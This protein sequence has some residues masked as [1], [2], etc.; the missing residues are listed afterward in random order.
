MT[1]LIDASPLQS[2]HRLRGVGAYVRSLVTAIESM[3]LQPQYLVSS[4]GAV[5]LLP[6]DRVTRVFR[7]HRPAQVYW[8]YNEL[9]LR[10]G[11]RRIRPSVF[12]APDFNGLVTNPYGKTVSVLHDLTHLK[13]T[14]AARSG[15]LSA[16]L[17]AL[18][19]SVYNCKLQQADC[20]LA[21]SESTRQDAIRLLGIHPDRLHVVHHGVD[22]C[23]FRPSRGRGPFAQHKPYFVQLGGRNDNKNQ[24]RLLQAFVQVAH[25][26]KDV[27]LLFSGPW[28]AADLNWLQIETEHLRIQGRVRHLGY[29]PDHDLSSL[30]GNAVAFVFPSLEEGFGLPIL[31]AMASGAA[32]ITSDRSSL[33]EVAGS[34]ALLVNPLDPADLAEAMLKVLTESDLSQQLRQAGLD[35]ARQFTWETT[36]QQTMT[37]IGRL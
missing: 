7:P 27:E 16:H 5:N 4:D 19:W 17:D 6:Q 21:I 32:V 11:L 37:V 22:H 13:L 34:A 3:G 29:V 8:M 25:L 12:L 15:G 24:A 18:R 28:S 36:V 20:I 14:R 2:E 35:R 9:A 23:R 33:P 26:D 31:E 30:Y 1:L 10:A